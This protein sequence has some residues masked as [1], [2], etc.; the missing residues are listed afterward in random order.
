[1]PRKEYVSKV[2][3]VVIKIGSSSIS[4]GKGLSSEKVAVFAGQIARLKNEGYEIVIVTSGAISAG[5]AECGKNRDFLTVPQKQALA[6]VGQSIL[7]DIYRDEFSHYS[8][9]IGQILMTEDDIKNRHRF[10]NIRNTMNML[11]HMGIVPVINEN[12]SVAVTEIQF[13]DNDTLSAHVAQL[14][15]ADLLILLS[16]IDGYYYNLSDSAP[17]DIIPVITDEIRAGAGGAGTSHGTGGMKTKLNAADLMLRSGE[18]MVIANA[19]AENVLLRILAGDMV[20]TLFAPED[21]PYINGRKRW[22]LFHSKPVGNLIVDE[23]ARSAIVTKNSSLLPIGIITAEGHFKPGDT[24]D[25]V[26]EG[27]HFARGIVNYSSEEISRIKRKK[28]GEIRELLGDEYY[29]EAVHRDN[30]SLL[31]RLS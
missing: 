6:A 20:G 22:I 17:A 11:L 26:C 5:A 24:V 3:R 4:S 21:Y 19:S 25:I 2:R 15:E 28:S 14:V 8:I 18:M 12:D 30:L 13:G 7:M 1:M 9:T 16:D 31:D 27:I 29:D 23:G 10:L